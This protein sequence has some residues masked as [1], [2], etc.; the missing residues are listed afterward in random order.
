MKHIT[1]VRHGQASFLE[2]GLRQVVCERRGASQIAGK[3]LVAA[4]MIFHNAYAGP[5]LRQQ[6]TARIV[7]EVFRNAGHSFRRSR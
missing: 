1:L 7:A 4:G 6:E 3:V 5:R 2:A